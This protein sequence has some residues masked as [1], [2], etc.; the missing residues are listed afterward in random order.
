MNYPEGLKRATNARLTKICL[1]KKK[2]WQ[3]MGRLG[4]ILGKGHIFGDLLYEASSFF[5]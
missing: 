5:L 2:N 4:P 1:T 3:K